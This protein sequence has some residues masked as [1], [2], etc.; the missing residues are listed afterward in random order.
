MRILCKLMAVLLAV[1]PTEATAGQM[2]VA[3]FK[4][5]DSSLSL[6]CEGDEIGLIFVNVSKLKYYSH[7]DHQALGDLKPKMRVRVDDQAPID[8]DVR[9]VLANNSLTASGDSDVNLLTTI[10]G[11]KNRITVSLDLPRS[12][13]LERAFDVQGKV[14]RV[15]KVRA[16]IDGC[17]LGD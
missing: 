15:E 2:H 3:G 6:W 9:V 7:W 17:G 1:A 8:V 13:G 14:E 11:A 12:I 16:M 5:H 10:R 4:G